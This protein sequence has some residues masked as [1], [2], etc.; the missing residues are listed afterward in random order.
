MIPLLFLFSVWMMWGIFGVIFFSAIFILFAVFWLWMLVD[1]LKREHF[2]DKIVWVIL[3]I[4][5]PILVIGTILYYFLVYSKYPRKKVTR[6][7]RK[8]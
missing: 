4:F 6:T 1:L 3:M 5:P 7:S 2:E 8:R